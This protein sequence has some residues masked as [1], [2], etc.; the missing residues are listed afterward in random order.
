MGIQN[1]QKGEGMRRCQS[2]CWKSS[3]CASG[4]TATNLS[5]FAV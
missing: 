1:C 4:L 3:A 5:A 2:A